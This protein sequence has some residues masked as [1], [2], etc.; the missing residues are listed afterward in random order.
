MYLN[1]LYRCDRKGLE[2]ANRRASWDASKES[3]RGVNS[4]A[5]SWRG[6]RGA[7]LAP[8]ARVVATHRQSCRMRMSGPNMEEGHMQ[9]ISTVTAIFIVSVGLANGQ[10]TPPTPAEQYKAL[11]KEYDIATGSSV[12]LTDAE[13]LKFVGRV[14]EHHFVVAVKFL[15]LA[16]KYPNDPIALDALIQAVWQVNTTPWPVEIVGKDTARAKAFELIQRDHIRSERL[17]PLCQ[18]ISYG[19]CKEYETFL[20]AVQAKNPHKDIKGAACL[21]LAQFLNNRLQRLELC[22]EQPELAKEFAGLYGKEYLAE[23]LRQDRDKALKE[24][25]S[26]FEQAVE[27]YADVKLASGD[28]IA[29][30]AKTEL[31]TIRNL[32]VGKE[33]PDIEGEDQEGKRF[34]LSDYRGKVVLLDIWSY[35]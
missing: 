16:E 8:R 3:V 33:A 5:S 2:P 32:T 21:S 19:F 14:Y 18:R 12:P 24:I 1:L 11:R 22:R 4:A 25:Q 10:D 20:R 26:V 15:E 29:E 31:F 30:R 7:E 35:V 9:R 6:L 27:Q 28:T 23:L 34:K 13:R 17:G